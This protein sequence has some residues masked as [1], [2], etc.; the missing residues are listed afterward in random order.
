MEVGWDFDELLSELAPLRQELMEGD[1]RPLYLGH[2]AV[3]VDINHDPDE[4]VEGPVPAGLDRLT[5]AQTAFSDLLGLDAH[6]IEAAATGS[7]TLG[8]IVRAHESRIIYRGSNRCRPVGRINGWR[9]CWQMPRHPCGSR[10]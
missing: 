9:R 8:H 3:C 2:L 4:L 6:L 1:L 7:P 10:S 5:A